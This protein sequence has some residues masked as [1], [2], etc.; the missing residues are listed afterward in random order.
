M[1]NTNYFKWKWWKIW[2]RGML[3]RLF[4]FLINLVDRRPCAQYI[5]ANRLIFF[6]FLKVVQQF[7][8]FYDIFIQIS[9]NML[10]IRNLG[11]LIILAII[12]MWY[13]CD[14]RCDH[15]GNNKGAFI[16]FKSIFILFIFFFF[17]WLSILCFT[18]IFVF[19]SFFF[20]IIPSNNYKRWSSGKTDFQ[21]W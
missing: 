15:V 6:L 12:T 18:R 21:T 7:D 13:G 3:F 16:D 1:I 8:V 19:S 10:K 9:L 4:L 2:V 17:L 11:V 5:I 14:V 20:K